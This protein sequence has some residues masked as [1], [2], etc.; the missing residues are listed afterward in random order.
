VEAARLTRLAALAPETARVMRISFDGMPD[1]QIADRVQ[2]GDYALLRYDSIRGRA[3][4]IVSMYPDGG[5][6]VE[7]VEGPG[8]T[9]LLCEIVERARIAGI[10]CDAWVF[11]IARAKLAE[12][13]GMQL[14][15]ATRDS[16]SG[17]Q[18]LQVKT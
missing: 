10:A 1:T 11:N 17:Q 15:G 8:G 12:R 16:Y 5:A 18:Q 4:A 3:H 14:T 9:Q 7:A 2:A 6:C 13:A